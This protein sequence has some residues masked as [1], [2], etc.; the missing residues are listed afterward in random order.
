MINEFLQG[1][2]GTTIGL[3]MVYYLLKWAVKTNYKLDKKRGHRGGYMGAMGWVQDGY[4]PTK[5][6]IPDMPPE[7]RMR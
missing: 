7:K 4:Q 5:I 3:I 6:E 1:V 2:A